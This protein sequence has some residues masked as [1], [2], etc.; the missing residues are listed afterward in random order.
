MGRIVLLHTFHF[1]NTLSPVFDDIFVF[2]E[3]ITLF[4]NEPEYRLRTILNKVSKTVFFQVRKILMMN[5]VH[6]MWKYVQIYNY[7][8]SKLT[9]SYTSYV[10]FYIY[11]FLSFQQFRFYKPS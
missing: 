10:F 9:H 2:H 5:F 8:F 6:N 1:V 7:Q 11:I 3:L 4:M